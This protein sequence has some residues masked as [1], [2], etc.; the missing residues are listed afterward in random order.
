MKFILPVET[1]DTVVKSIC[2][3]ANGAHETRE[4]RY[5]DE[6]LRVLITD[7]KNI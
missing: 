4:V 7:E 5:Q 6:V 2:V 3:T 1:P